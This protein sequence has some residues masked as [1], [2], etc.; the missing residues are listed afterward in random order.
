MPWKPTDCGRPSTPPIL[1]SWPPAPIEK[2]PM[3]PPDSMVK[4][5][6]PSL[7]VA[8][9]RLEVPAGK[10]KTTVLPIGGNAPVAL[11]ENPEMVADAVFE[12]KRGFPAGDAIIQQVRTP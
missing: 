1:V 7:L 5:N 8:R 11:I 2:A 6:L 12:G 10:V 4:R 9:S 3:A